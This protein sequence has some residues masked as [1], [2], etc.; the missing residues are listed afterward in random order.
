[1][2]AMKKRMSISKL[3]PVWGLTSIIILIVILVLLSD[4]FSV[5]QTDMVYDTQLKPES[6]TLN[7][8]QA[9]EQAILTSYK[10]I[11]PEKAVYRIPVERAM[12]LLAEEAA[13]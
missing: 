6:V 7:D 8:L 12:Q 10:L 13:K 9:E 5:M 2:F 3:L 1:M 4:Y 11:D